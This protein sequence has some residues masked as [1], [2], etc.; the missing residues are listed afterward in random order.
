[1]YVY[2]VYIHKVYMS[3]DCIYASQTSVDSCM[4][5]SDM[6]SGKCLI[7]KLKSMGPSFSSL[8]TSWLL[9]YVCRIYI[10]VGLG[11]IRPIYHLIGQH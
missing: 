6:L 8:A 3:V 4:S 1:M 10:A 9:I 11:N 7:L 2:I 5:S